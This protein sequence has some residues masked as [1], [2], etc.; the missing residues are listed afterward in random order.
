MGLGR[1]GTIA[2]ATAVAT[3]AI[4]AAVFGALGDLTPQGC[5]ADPPDTA[6]CG[7]TAQGLFGASG[8]A[9]SRDGASVYAVSV[10]DDAIV[11]FDRAPSGVL[12]P[13]G[14]MA[15]PPDTAGCGAT[16]EGLDGAGGVAVSPD[17]ASV[18]A[19]SSLDDAIVRFDRA[20]S[21]ALDPEGCIEDVETNRACDDIGVS[22]EA[23]GLNN[24]QD[25]AVS[26]DGASVYAVSNLDDAIVRFDRAPSGVLSNASCIEDVETNGACDDVGASG[27]AQGLNGAVSVAVSPDGASVYAIGSEDDAI[28]RFD[29][30]PSGAL[31]SAGC[32]AD[33]PDTAA[34]GATAQGLNGAGGVAVSPDNASVYAVSQ[35]DDAIVRFDRAAGGALTPAGCIADPPDTAGCAA[36]AQGLDQASSDAVSPD[37]ASVYAV[38]NFDDAIVRF[39]R[40]AG[41]ALTPAGCIADP[42]D[43]AGCG[44][45]AQGL[46]G[47]KGV[48]VSP[49]GASVYAV[50]PDNAIVRFDRE[51]P[52]APGPP[53]GEAADTTPPETTIT[54]GPKKKTKKKKA[55]F[56]F[57]SS[58]PGSTFDCKL[59]KHD[60]EPCV[61]PD[62]LKV[63]KGKHTFEVRAK[64]P[65]GNVDPTPASQSWKVKKKK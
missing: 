21:G 48:A 10:T 6:G 8:V 44:A 39:D 19:V 47:A 12:T 18:Y 57:T 60:F 17:G 29:R 38:S 23:Q 37:G 52:L 43:T 46:N 41:G 1:F 4:S 31:T 50:S 54:K 22:G 9:V 32:I 5:I 51:L 14:C 13:Q 62:K 27:E 61:P 53:G 16:A 34:C 11:R 40:T 24:V 36:T 35:V 33:P 20:A 28:V 59:D 64:D 45:T 42:P 49:D 55:T 7:A 2:I 63:K 15:D 25:V 65:A 56:E 30:A 26:P 3:L 58:E